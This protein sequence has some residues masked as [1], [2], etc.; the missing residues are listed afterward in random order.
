VFL[1]AAAFLGG[2]VPQWIKVRNLRTEVQTMDLQ[3]R[4]ANAHRLLG[5]ASEEAQRSNYASS[6]QAAAQFFDQCA[7]LARTETFE[8]E[9]RTRVALLSYTAQRDQV[10]ALLSAADPAVREKLMGMFLTMD[11]VLARRE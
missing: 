9:P 10:M 2:F 4:L 3:L 11:G 1:L 8:K 7:T 5:V 6:A